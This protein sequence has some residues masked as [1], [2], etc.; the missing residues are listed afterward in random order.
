M[1][2]ALN[3]SASVRQGK[4]VDVKDVIPAVIYGS[5][6]D[7]TSL[8]VKRNEFENI[9]AKSGESGLIKLSIDGKEEP[10]IVKDLQMDAVKHRIIHVDF[11]KVNMKEKVTAEVSL[12]FIGES[13]AVKTYGGIVVHNLDTIEIECLPS[14]LI[15]GIDVDLSKLAELGDSLTVADL[16]LP[17]NVVATNG[18]DEMIVHVVEPKKSVA[19]AAADAAIE[20]ASAANATAT[21]AGG[22][23]PADAKAEEKK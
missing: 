9:F 19:D 20:T 21:A 16:Q 7:N 8:A 10:V 1:S 5:G 11:F 22:A 3:L 12:N 14:D 17:A 4:V 2:E 15:Q 18:A 13:P 6:I 23:K